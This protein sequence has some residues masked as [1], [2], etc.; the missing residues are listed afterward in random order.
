MLL[1]EAWTKK[2]QRANL[3]KYNRVTLKIVLIK[4]GCLV[5]IY[6]IIPVYHAVFNEITTM[7]EM[8]N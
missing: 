2:E 1:K 7:I 8:I 3:K 6:A 5:G 4:L